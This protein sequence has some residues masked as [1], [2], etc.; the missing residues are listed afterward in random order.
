MN[1][2]VAD[3]Q[4]HHGNQDDAEYDAYLGRLKARFHN[5]TKGGTVPLFTVDAGDL[6]SMYLSGFKPGQQRQYHNC[7]ACRHFIN[8]FG[9]LVTIDEF[10][11]PHSALWADEDAP[12]FYKR[13][14]LKMD[15][16]VRDSP[17]T[18]VFLSSERTWG[19]PVTGPWR[20]FSVTPPA[21]MLHRHAVLTAAQTMAEK[22]EDFHNVARALGEFPLNVIDRALTLLRSDALYR[23]EKVIGPAQFLRDLH[24]ARA[25]VKNGFARH[26]ILWRA[27]ATAPAGFCHPRSSMIGTL[28]EDLVAGMDFDEVSRRFKEKMHPLQYQRPQA[29]PTAGNIAAG[30]KLIAQMGLQ[31]SL[32][33][34]FAR[35]EE[36]RAF[37]TAPK[38]AT[39]E[40]GGIFGHLVPKNAARPAEMSAVNPTPITMEKFCRAVLPQAESLDIWVPGG[41]LT[42]IVFTTAS[43]PDAP[44]LLQWDRPD[45][46]NPFAWY[47]W[48]GGAPASQYGL[49]AGRYHRVTAIVSKP[50]MW[51]DPDDHSHQGKGAAFIIEGARETRTSAGLAL[52]PETLRSELHGIRST[53]EA[54]SKAGKLENPEEATACGLLVSGSAGVNVRVLQGSV[55]M[56]YH[57][58]RWD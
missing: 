50:T 4:H 12:L 23:A 56:A 29:A 47:L 48:N 36:L 35:A 58:E 26:N 13:A 57:I 2:P 51:D 18:G 8:R 3:F 40:P 54:F 44:P 39:P 25:A 1:T 17:I 10:G 45:R 7:S 52:F 38:P 30:E 9:S 32:H 46:R 11:R 49:A 21:T 42:F 19:T 53:I 31:A 5:N 27:V 34:R 15:N 28:L 20:H 33:R 37:W 55:T 41:P 6:F 43:D 22:R 24:V 14:I 16:A